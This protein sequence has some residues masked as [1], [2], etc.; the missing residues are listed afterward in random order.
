MR[1]TK[2]GWADE[3]GNPIS[4]EDIIETL[5]ISVNVMRKEMKQ[6]PEIGGRGT[7]TY[8]QYDRYAQVL[9]IVKEKFV[10]TKI[11][12]EREAREKAGPRLIIPKG[13][14]K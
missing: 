2:G 4:I 12:L 5:S 14:I 6:N 10:M 9:G 7:K 3:K 8:D 1:K 11:Q 13:V